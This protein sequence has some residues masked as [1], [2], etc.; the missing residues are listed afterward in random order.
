MEPRRLFC[1]SAWIARRHAALI[2]SGGS[3]TCTTPPPSS[4]NARNSAAVAGRRIVAGI[5]FTEHTSMTRTA[6]SGQMSADLAVRQTLG[7]QRQHQV[8]L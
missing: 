8:V 6:L 7:R 3:A 1:L 5:I 4:S 2:C